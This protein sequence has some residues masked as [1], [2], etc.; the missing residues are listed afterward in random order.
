MWMAA[1]SSAKTR[2]ALLPDAKNIRVILA[3]ER[4]A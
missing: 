2:F 1:T 3:F 4:P